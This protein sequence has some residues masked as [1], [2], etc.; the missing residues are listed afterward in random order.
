LDS[1]HQKSIFSS[2]ISLTKKKEAKHALEMMKRRL[3][4]S[5]GN[6][7]LKDNNRNK[8]VIKVAG[9]EGEG[10]HQQVMV[11]KKEHLLVN[12]FDEDE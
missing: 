4:F 5:Q 3:N 1:L 11:R 6:R 10:G 7:V 8:I 12:S 9:G 2:F